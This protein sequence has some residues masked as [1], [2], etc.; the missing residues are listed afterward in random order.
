MGPQGAQ[1]DATN[2]TKQTA[3]GD[4]TPQR[5]SHPREPRLSRRYGDATDWI[6]QTALGDHMPQR[7]SHPREPR[8]SRRYGDATD[9]IKQ[10]ALGD[11]MPQWQSHPREPRL[12]RRYGD[13]TNRTKQTALGDHT[14]QRQSRM[15][16]RRDSV[17]SSR[18]QPK[19]NTDRGAD[20]ASGKEPTDKLE[21]KIRRSRTTFT[22]YQLHALERA[23]DRSQYPDV[24]TREELALR[25]DLTEARVQV[26]GHDHAQSWDHRR[27]R[28]SV[29]S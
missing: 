23:F 20:D 3:L 16:S 18:L 2:R 22:T 1:G 15:R 21:R 6:K 5:Q 25:L 17:P 28:I 13:A 24:F 29:V 7:Q 12:S 19:E 26:V 9:W 11:H 27:R 14:P 8:L 10:T 4:H